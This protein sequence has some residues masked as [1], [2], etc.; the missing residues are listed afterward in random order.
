MYVYNIYTN[1]YTNKYTNIY[2]LIYIYTHIYI[3][4]YICKQTN[5]PTLTLLYSVNCVIQL[6]LLILIEVSCNNFV[7]HYIF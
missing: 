1:I 6:S 2:I 3:V 4:I 5:I 7:N